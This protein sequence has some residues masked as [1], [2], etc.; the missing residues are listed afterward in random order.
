MK[1]TSLSLAVIATTILSSTALAQQP[2]GDPKGT[3]VWEPVPKIVT[4]GKTASDAP[5]DAIVLFDGKN[6]DQW[7]SVKDGSSPAQWMVD[8]R[9][10]FFTVKKGTGN[11]QTKRS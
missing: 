2:K 3:E 6:L 8:S 7:V 4:P 1:K 9:D 10:G 5:S 11:I